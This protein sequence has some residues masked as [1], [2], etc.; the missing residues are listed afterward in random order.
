MANAKA[1][2]AAKKAPAK[3][4]K[5]PAELIVAPAGIAAHAY[6]DK[7]DTGGEYS[8]DKY[9]VTVLYP[10]ENAE[11]KHASLNQ[12]AIDAYIEKL[13]KIHVAAGGSEDGGPVKDGDEKE[14]EDYHGFWLVKYSSQFQ[15]SLV[16]AKKKEL[17]NGVK[18]YGGDIVKVVFNEHTFTSKNKSIGSGLST[19]RL[20][21]VQL[22]DKRN[23]GKGARAIA[24]LEEEDGYTA[25]DDA[26]DEDST[27]TS[28]GDY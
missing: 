10:K 6:L 28:G 16:D 26:S 15:P 9:K 25:D 21:V 13:R 1:K 5:E 19:S 17:R 24:A 4:K 22:L 23:G 2:P 27:D 18:I 11:E 3:G 7:P 14:K 8:D 20:Q 12:D